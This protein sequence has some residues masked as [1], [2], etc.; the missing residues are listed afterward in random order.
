MK[1][2]YDHIILTPTRNRVDALE[3][4]INCLMECAKQAD[5]TVCH[6]IFD[7][8]SDEAY[9]YL[10]M[11]N[12][13]DGYHKNYKII[14]HRM[15]KRYGRPRFTELFTE[16]FR[17]SKNLTYKYITI[18]SDDSTPCK[19]YFNRITEHFVKRKFED[20]SIVSMNINWHPNSKMWGTNRYLDC[21]VF[22]TK[23][24]LV[25]MNFKIPAAE[26]RWLKNPRRS[27]GVG[28]RMT[29]GMEKHSRYNTATWD[30]YS[31]FKV[32]KLG[33]ASQL[34][35]TIKGKGASSNARDK[36]F[37]DYPGHPGNIDTGKREAVKEFVMPEKAQS[38]TKI[39]MSVC[40]PLYR[41]NH[42]G[43]VALES[44][45]RQYG[46]NFG[47]ELIVAEEQDGHIIG[48]KF[49]MKYAYRLRRVGCKRITYI[50]LSKWIPLGLKYSLMIQNCHNNS[51]IWVGNSAGYYSSL[52]RLKNIYDAFKTSNCDMFH[53]SQALIY[54]LK[55]NKTYT[56]RSSEIEKIPGK[57]YAMSLLRNISDNREVNGVDDWIYAHCKEKKDLKIY[58]DPSDVWM[59]GVYVK[60]LNV[61]ETAVNPE[62]SSIEPYTRD[63]KYIL[64]GDIAMK[65]HEC[66]SKIKTHKVDIEKNK[67]S[68]LKKI[69]ITTSER[70]L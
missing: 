9:D 43:W 58:S 32:S 68:S 29:Q 56:F 26:S 41:A 50:A 52:H 10:S 51:K 23:D 33:L 49:I 39:E 21:G 12:K 61:L 35:P 67:I 3:F 27:T 18:T 34:Y 65:L 53:L 36:L 19:D 22:G 55:S 6:L 8:C 44:L 64:P 14:Y 69:N 57:G 48:K 31:F 16:M 37:V 20:V 24:F 25:A 54:D 40:L 28:V 45:A 2:T 1:K 47:W 5:V 30:G 13:L 63:I 7:D 66:R 46:V 17:I 11:L 70:K 42:I 60:G 62:D 15:E 59:S 38:K 4:K